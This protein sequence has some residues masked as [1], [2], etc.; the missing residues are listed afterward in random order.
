[1]HRS[2]SQKLTPGGK[3]DERSE[4]HIISNCTQGLD[5]SS[6]DRSDTEP[7]LR[8]IFGASFGNTSYLLTNP[9]DTRQENQT[10]P[11]K[12]MEKKRSAIKD[13]N[14]LGMLAGVVNALAQLFWTISEVTQVGRQSKEPAFPLVNYNHY[15]QT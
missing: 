13:R 5:C 10:H 11:R 7:H 12:Q 15:I 1:M 4:K 2:P 14:L 9:S 3:N 8:F 6:E